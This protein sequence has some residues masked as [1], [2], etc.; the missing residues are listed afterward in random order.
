MVFKRRDRPPVLTRLREAVLPRRGWRRGLEYLGHRVRRLPDTPHRIAL[1]FSCGVLASFTPLFGLHFVLA[2]A[3][4]K[5]V[6]GNI[7]AALLGTLVGNPLTF[8]VIAW[9]S[10][11]L[12]RKIVGFGATG[13][14]FDR[15]ADAFAEAAGALW[16]SSLALAGLGHSQWGH[17]VP[18]LRDVFWPYLIGGIGPGVAA[19]VASYYLLVPLVTTYQLHRRKRMQ[20]RAH[21]RLRQKSEADGPRAGAYKHDGRTAAKN[22]SDE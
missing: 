3:F 13:R 10:L 17:V 1:G 21:Q 9:S 20:E 2:A 7:L 19:S 8:P 11:W 5:L 15:V 4:A 6:R 18:F 16:Q 22:G 12:G 14:D